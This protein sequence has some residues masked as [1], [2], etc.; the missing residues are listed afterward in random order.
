MFEIQHHS[1]FKWE[2]ESYK[3]T[4]NAHKRF[5]SHYEKNQTWHFQT[6]LRFKRNKTHT[7]NIHKASM[8][9]YFFLTF[10]LQSLS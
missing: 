3:N 4:T 7:H 1:Y 2:C 9:L 10:H 5:T 6:F 8:I